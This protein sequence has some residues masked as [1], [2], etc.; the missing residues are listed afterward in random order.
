[1]LLTQMGHA[2]IDPARLPSAAAV[3]GGGVRLIVPIAI[4]LVSFALGWW[5]FTRE[6]PRVAENL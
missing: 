1:M 6:A 5:V 4:I 2:F 3:A